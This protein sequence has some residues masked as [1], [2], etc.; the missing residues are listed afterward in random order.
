MK[1]DDVR[2][3]DKKSEEFFELFKVVN[4]KYFD[5]DNPDDYQTAASYLNT[6]LHGGEKW[7]IVMMV[8]LA[9]QLLSVVEEKRPAVTGIFGVKDVEVCFDFYT[10][11]KKMAHMKML[12]NKVNVLAKPNKDAE[13]AE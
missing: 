7:L 3:M 11:K 13:E 6:I 8:R 5:F 12:T 1:L 4:E 9:S 2:K 10:D